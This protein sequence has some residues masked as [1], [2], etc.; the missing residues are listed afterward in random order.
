MFQIVVTTYK[1]GDVRSKPQ[2]KTH[3]HVLKAKTYQLSRLIKVVVANVHLDLDHLLEGLPI[4]VVGEG[5]GVLLNT[6]HHQYSEE[7]RVEV[8]YVC[9]ASVG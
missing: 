6:S 1:R 4:Q 3:V 9:L 5:D 2:H 8:T 7:S